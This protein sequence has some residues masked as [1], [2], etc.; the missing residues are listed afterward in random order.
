MRKNRRYSVRKDALFRQWLNNTRE[1]VQDT[2]FHARI[3]KKENSIISNRILLEQ[4]A[5]SYYFSQKNE[6]NSLTNDP[7]SYIRNQH[8]YKILK[9]LK[10]GRY[11]PD[12]FLDLHGLNQYQAKKELAKLIVICQKE[13]LFCAHIMHGYGQNILKTQTP[14]WLSQHPDIIALHQAPKAFG[15]DAAIMVIIEIHSHIKS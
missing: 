11:S 4:D 7:V 6:N 10:K 1:I 2:I 3:D 9:N 8:A 15:N 12:I 14:F 5:H 13:K